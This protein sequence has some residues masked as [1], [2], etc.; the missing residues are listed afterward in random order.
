MP[1]RTNR[2]RAAVYRRLW[3]WPLR[4]PKHL[5][6]ALVGF[7]VVVT[8]LAIVVAKLS[9]PGRQPVAAPSTDDTTTST[10][11]NVA[12]PVEPSTGPTTSSPL[13]TRLPAP[14]SPS[15]AA[16]D[17]EALDVATRWT[18]AWAN[19]P[20]GVSTY[21]WLQGMRPY[22]TEEYMTIMESIDPAN[23]PATK[24]TGPA[25]AI[26]SV[27]GSIDVRV[28]TDSGPL[29]I[30]LIKTTEGWRVTHYDQGT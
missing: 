5:V 17:P 10:T 21:Q 19:H 13:P 4:S 15:T 25:T 12:P 29:A 18:A 9:G 26:S 1:I 27:A 6:I 23:V 3:G 7:A 24:V 11:Q 22:T 20:A 16:P 2:G 28:P 8:V 14:P 30:T